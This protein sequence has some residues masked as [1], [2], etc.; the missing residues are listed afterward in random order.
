[1]PGR[2]RRSG[3]PCPMACLPPAACHLLTIAHGQESLGEAFVPSAQARPFRS[4]Y[5]F[6]RAIP[7][8]AADGPSMEGTS[9]LGVMVGRRRTCALP[10]RPRL[11]GRHGGSRH[12]GGAVVRAPQGRHPGA[13]AR[14]PR[15][16]S[17]PARGRP[18]GADPPVEGTFSYVLAG[19][20]GGGAFYSTCQPGRQ[21]SVMPAVTHDVLQYCM[22][23]DQDKVRPVQ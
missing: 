14:P 18:A 13:A 19:V 4:V 10:G 23:V 6:W 22:A 15:P 2:A 16:A 17:R 1:M 20:E 3:A 5:R 8:R 7:D 11:S 9:S 21:A 12:G